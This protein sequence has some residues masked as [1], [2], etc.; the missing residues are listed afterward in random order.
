M[1]IWVRETFADAGRS[2]NKKPRRAATAMWGVLLLF[3]VVLTLGACGED[4]T[5]ATAEPEAVDAVSVDVAAVEPAVVLDPASEDPAVLAV[6][7]YQDVLRRLTLEAGEA[8]AY[9]V[10]FFIRT[11]MSL[12]GESD[13][14]T[15]A[16][17]NMTVVVDEDGDMRAAIVMHAT[18]M[19][20]FGFGTSILEMYIAT[21]EE[22]VLLFHML[23][24]GEEIPLSPELAEEIFE[25][26]SDDIMNMPEI[27]LAA[28]QTAEIEEVDDNRVIRIGLYGPALTQF[29][30]ESMAELLA[31]AEAFGVELYFA[32]G[33]AQT[34][35]VTDRA[36]T[37][38]SMATELYVWM[39]IAGE[40][41]ILDM[42]IEYTFL[43][44]D[45][46]VGME[47]LTAA[48]ERELGQT[49]DVMPDRQAAAE[50]LPEDIDSMTFRLNGEIFTF[51]VPFAELEARGWVASS[52]QI[53][54]YRRRS[55]V[56]IRNGDQS[57][58]VRFVNLSGDALPLNETYVHS[59]YTHRTHG[60]PPE[61]VFPGEII[62][63]GRM[64]YE[65]VIA[66]HGEPSRWGGTTMASEMVGYHMIYTMEYA[67]LLIWINQRTGEVAGMQLLMNDHN[68]SQ[69]IVERRPGPEIPLPTGSI[70]PAP[71]GLSDD[72]FSLMFSL[73]GV[74]YTMPLS[75]ADLEADGWEVD[76]LE[77]EDFEGQI[78]R[79]NHTSR[80]VQLRLGDQTIS[81]S[82]FNPTEEE[83]LLRDGVI[84]DIFIAEVLNGRVQLVFPG[85]IAIGSTY[86]EVIAAHGE[87]SSVLE[88]EAFRFRTLTYSAGDISV[89]FTV[90]T[91]TN[92][93]TNLSMR[94]NRRER[95][96]IPSFAADDFPAAVIAYQVPRRLGDHWSTF[97][98][99]IDGDLYRL[100]APMAVFAENGWSF[101]DIGMTVSPTARGAGV[102]LSRG[103]AILRTRFHNYDADIRPV[104][105]T[106]VVRVDLDFSNPETALS[107]ELPGGITENS[108]MEEVMAVFGEP[109][110]IEESRGRRAYSF[111]EEFAGFAFTVHMRTL[112]IQEI[113]ITHCVEERENVPLYFS[114]AAE[115]GELDAPI[116]VQ[117]KPATK[118]VE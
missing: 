114:D 25:E 88:R 84:R 8:G 20:G 11:Q 90:D 70:A 13:F 99:V 118:T 46:D 82:F 87:P 4:L 39:D 17:G 69:A 48:I 103:E 16:T 24:D 7:A 12:V 74:L 101:P 55:N 36:G 41:A 67:N 68:V 52:F 3:V 30:R 81:V 85:N 93:V 45:E 18:H 42:S 104:R 109:V 31:E 10:D 38:L 14:F 26:I 61:V 43:A 108:T 65:D 27:H 1:R 80:S 29:A 9:D 40:E 89:S 107:I 50:A 19:V 100:P 75:F 47:G 62:T 71:A 117:R 5:E 111:G 76:D 64:T 59:I 115:E 57:M 105:H 56:P 106:F 28:I 116:R 113:V 95:R 58:I 34:T 33:G 54:P 110:A 51:P 73:N 63:T 22:E 15:G 79:P 96:V 2:V 91:N 23:V 66:I 97:T 83:V 6:L 32:M 21:E 112:E 60:G 77:A 72:V 44:F 35:I 98:V 86:E 102:G 92:L 94:D 53:E 78:L 49:I 37:P